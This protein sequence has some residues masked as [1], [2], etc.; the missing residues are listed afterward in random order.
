MNPV[1]PIS[2]SQSIFPV[3]KHSLDAVQKVYDQVIDEIN[4][5]NKNG[6]HMEIGIIT[7]EG[8]CL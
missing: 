5:P 3:H 2:P 7:S 4:P 8:A 1:N 6:A